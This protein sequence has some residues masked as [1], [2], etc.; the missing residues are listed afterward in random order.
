MMTASKKMFCICLSSVDVQSF[1]SKLCFHQ[2]NCFCILTFDSL[3]FKYTNIFFLATGTGQLWVWA[4]WG[5]RGKEMKANQAELIYIWNKLIAGWHL[6]FAYQKE[7]NFITTGCFTPCQG[8]VKWISILLAFHHGLAFTVTSHTLSVPWQ[9]QPEGKCV[10]QNLPAC[11]SF[12]PL[13]GTAPRGSCM[14]IHGRWWEERNYRL[15]KEGG[16]TNA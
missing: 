5:L 14:G 1:S 9:H 12:N 10:P 16:D 15:D 8:R 13:P 4:D 6:L 3:F 11:R 2:V 7:R